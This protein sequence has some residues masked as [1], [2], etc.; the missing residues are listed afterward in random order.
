MRQTFENLRYD[1]SIGIEPVLNYFGRLYYLSFDENYW[2]FIGED[3]SDIQT[4]ADHEE[5]LTNA[6]IDGKLLSEVWEDVARSMGSDIIITFKLIS[7]KLN[8]DEVTEALQLQPTETTATDY[9]REWIYT[10]FDND[11]DYDLPVHDKTFEF[12]NLFTEKIEA[13]NKIVKNPVVI[14]GFTYGVTAYIDIIGDP[15]KYEK[16]FS[17]TKNFLEFALATNIQIIF[18]KP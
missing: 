4:F 16:Y 13:I 18:H 2:Y 3:S 6:K 12:A 9:Y 10:M 14:D 17:L 1:L 15:L 8:F 11:V 5:L 7:Q